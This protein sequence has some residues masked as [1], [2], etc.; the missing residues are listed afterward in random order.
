MDD[1]GVRAHTRRRALPFL[2]AAAAAWGV[3][4]AGATDSPAAPTAVVAG[5]TNLVLAAGDT[6]HVGVYARRGSDFAYSLSG[7]FVG[8]SMPPAVWSTSDT[9]VATVSS[10]GLVSARGVGRAVLTITVG[11]AR[12]T[13]TVHVVAQAQ[14]LVL[15]SV[16][17]GDGFTCG[18]LPDGRAV[19]WGVNY[20][21]QLGIGA[22]RRYTATLAPV[23]VRAT[24]GF[25]SLTAG[26]AHACGIATSGAAYCWGGNE[27]APLGDGSRVDRAIPT[28][29]QGTVAFDSIAAGAFHTCGLPSSGQVHCWGDNRYGQLGSDAVGLADVPRAAAGDLRFVAVSAGGVHTCG[30]RAD[31]AAYCWGDDAYGQ[32]GAGLAVG[33]R[34]AAPVR[35][36]AA[37]DFAAISAGDTHTCGLSRAGQLY[38]W[39]SNTVGQLGTGDAV[40]RDLPAAVAGG[41]T[42]RSVDA[43]GAHT[44]AVGTDGAPYCWGGNDRGQVGNGAALGGPVPVDG[45][46]PYVVTAPARVAAMGSVASLAAGS[47][48]HTCAL[49]PGGE[50]YCWGENGS[51][52]LGL[53]RFTFLAGVQTPFTPAPVSVR[54]PA[55]P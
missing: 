37:V 16:V 29:V 28:R 11:P 34:S 33:A 43:G 24:E 25:R 50:A 53:G 52:A 41:V 39:G 45:P 1:A 20:F 54:A 15:R 30:V 38:C 51:G 46:N 32:L 13:A 31:G 14:A 12:D 36:A 49:A 48:R 2:S 21:G 18:M 9:A 27:R 23:L 47:E 10:D 40:P 19:C 26:A 7:A 5:A 4:C 42:F 17:A 22:A 55:G 6:S 8:P 3:G 44:C 35:V